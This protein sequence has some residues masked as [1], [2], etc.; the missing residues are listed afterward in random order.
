MSDEQWL[1][2]RLSGAVPQPPEAPGRATAAQS[3]A[4]RARRRTTAG[5]VVGA[6]GVVAVVAALATTLG[7]SDGGAGPAG[8]AASDPAA[9]TDVACPPPPSEDSPDPVDEIDPDAP[10]EV[11]AGATVVRLCQGVGMEIEVPEEALTTDVDGL[12]DLVNGL[13][14]TD[15]PQICTNDYG[16]GYRLVFGYPDGSTFVVSS[17]LY[18]CRL[19]VVGSTYRVDADAPIDG[20][21]ERLQLQGP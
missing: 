10:G 21:T 14:E 5:A 1:R 18:G 6:A 15:E 12:V 4:R 20:F 7:G 8:P 11:P 16:Q 9:P 19:N 2:D 3:R 17:Q 13:A